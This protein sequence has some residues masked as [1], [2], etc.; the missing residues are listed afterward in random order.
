MEGDGAG[1]VGARDLLPQ[2][3]QELG[4]LAQNEKHPDQRAR[5][6]FVAGEE[7]HPQLID[8]FLSRKAGAAVRVFAAHD[9]AGDVVGPLSFREREARIH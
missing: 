9:G 2:G 5:R 6:G 4:P 8:Q 7:K 3:P 1:T